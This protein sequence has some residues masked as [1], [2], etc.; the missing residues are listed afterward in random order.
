MA[1]CR[2]DAEKGIV[3]DIPEGVELPPCVWDF[4]VGRRYMVEGWF[5]VVSGHGFQDSDGL[6]DYKDHKCLDCPPPPEAADAKKKG[7]GK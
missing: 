2:E 4:E 6:L 3:Q 7:A 5:N 1:K